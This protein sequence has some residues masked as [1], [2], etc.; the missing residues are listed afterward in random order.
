MLLACLPDHEVFKARLLKPLHTFKMKQKHSNRLPLVLLATICIGTP[1]P[2]A[3]ITWDTAATEG[4]QGGA[5]TWDTSAINWTIDGGDTNIAWDNT[6]HATDMAV[7]TTGNGRVTIPGEIGLAGI[8]VTS[9]DSATVGGRASMTYVFEGPGTLGFGSQQAMIETI[10]SGLLGIQIGNAITGTA[11]LEIN[12]ANAPP[13]GQGWVYLAGDNSA[14]SG[15]IHVRNGMVG[16]ASQ[17]A[18]GANAIT[19]D[20]NAGLFGPI[21]TVG[22]DTAAIDGPTSLTLDNAITILGDGNVLRVWGGRTL[23]LDGTLSGSGNASRTDGGTLVLSG[24]T[25]SYT[26]TL[27][28]TGAITSITG[29]FGGNLIANGGTLDVGGNVAGGLTLNNGTVSIA[30]DLNGL[31]LNSGSV[32]VAGDLTGA[33]TFNQGSLSLGGTHTGDVDLATVNSRLFLGPDG[34]INGN[35]TTQFNSSQTISIEGLVNG[36]VVIDELVNTRLSGAEITGNLTFGFDT[37]STE[38]S[39]SIADATVVVGGNLRFIGSDTTLRINGT[40]PSGTPIIT[41]AN[42]ITDTADP[43]DHITIATSPNMTDVVVTYNS[44][45]IV[46]DY[47]LAPVPETLTWD[48]DPDIPG[49]QIN[50]GGVWND[51]NANVPN[52]NWTS[53]DGATNINWFNGSSALFVGDLPAIAGGTR[54]TLEGELSVDG[55]TRTGA[56]GVRLVASTGN[57]LAI[58]GTVDVES[59]LV[60][61]AD[62][63][64]QFT[65]ILTKTG[66]G[67]LEINGS[68]AHFSFTNVTLNEGSIRFWNGSGFQTN[69]LVLNGGAIGSG[70]ALARSMDGAVT[71]GGNIGIGSGTGPGLSTGT[72]NFGA[73]GTVDLGGASRTLTIGS[74]VNFNGV[75]SNGGI[76]KEGDGRLTISNIDNTL[77]GATVVNAGELRVSSASAQTGLLGTLG[78]GPV[79]VNSGATLRFFTGSTTN[80]KSYANAITLDNATLIGSDGTH[81]LTGNLELTGANTIEV[82]WGNKNL[83]LEGVVSGSGS[84]QKTGPAM[85]VLSAN[86]TYTGDTEVSGGTLSL[87]Q[88]SLADSSNVRITT[89]GGTTL[90]LPHG[91]SDTIAEFWVNGVKQPDGQYDANNTTFITGTGS[92]LVQSSVQNAFDV[93]LAGAGLTPGAPGTAPSESA[94]GSGVPNLLQFALGGDPSD[95]SNNG[96]QVLFAKDSLGDDELVLT[97]AV[98]QGAAFAG[99]PT[100]SASIDGVSYQIQGGLDLVAWDSVV[101]EVTITNPGSAITAPTGY[102]LK[103]FRLAPASGLPSLGFLRLAV[104]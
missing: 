98:R 75:V 1:L 25:T 4:I 92:L 13:T 45:S 94:D 103:S 91:Q 79:N 80:A 56:N 72:M 11:G 55:I 104:D 84:I 20:G 22:P 97:I 6:T 14:L 53:D 8:R 7:F 44:N 35:I 30:G 95:A 85:L 33:L 3:D 12:A 59:S 26:G 77:S 51:L 50:A 82:Q 37:T 89:V 60:M 101:E 100:P 74:D 54:F 21:N 69:S 87:L 43:A 61:V 83:I 58:S 17:A 67:F 49:I 10:D 71:I 78:S 63:A 39:A 48:S 66:P 2:A 31:D 102:E 36:N 42:L 73:A 24:D 41:F 29:A 88:P 47:T 57:T 81:T 68:D 46:V 52:A 65:G 5:G 96:V 70:S 23:I 40:I 90:D 86:N 62:G 93:W 64:D 18:L 27:T 99:S 9:T 16:V 15:G 28:H 76:T 38:A 19:L 34:V 32:S